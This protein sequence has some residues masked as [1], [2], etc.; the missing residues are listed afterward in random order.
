MPEPAFVAPRAARAYHSPGADADLPFHYV[1]EAAAATGFKAVP[2]RRDGADMMRALRMAV[3]V[4]A[5]AGVAA[6]GKGADSA[7]RQGALDTK[8]LDSAQVPIDS[9]AKLSPAEMHPVDSA[10]AAPVAAKPAAQTSATHPTH[11]RRTSHTGTSSTGTHSSGTAASS[12]ATQTASAPAE[13]KHTRRD[14]VIGGVAGAAI[15]A[16]AGGGRHRVKGAVIGGAAGAIAGA[17]I[18][19]N[20]D[21]TRR[22]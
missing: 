20:V 17:V 11:T 21:K 9:S 7:S 10:A 15:G 4:S 18:G 22:P 12:G 13:V 2:T 19:N 5:I 8:D 16:V 3:V 1:A 6:C 14:A